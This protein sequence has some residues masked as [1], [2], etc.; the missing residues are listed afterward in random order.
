MA[1]KK[2]ASVCVSLYDGNFEMGFDCVGV[3]SCRFALCSVMPPDGTEDCAY[4]S[5]ACRSINAQIAAANNLKSM[6][7]KKMNKLTEGTE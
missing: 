3:E 5:G 7:T 6:I 4:N 2:T 1:A